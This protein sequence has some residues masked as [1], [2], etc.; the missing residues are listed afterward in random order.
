MYTK[1]MDEITFED[2]ENFCDAESEGPRVEYKQEVKDIPKIVSS[3]ANTHGGIY[4]I[5]VVAEKKNNR[6]TSIPGISEKNGIEEQI[7]QS[8]IMGIHPAVIPE[9]KVLGVPDSDNKVVVIVRVD[10]SLQAPHA[11]E[12][13]TRVYF[14]PGSITQPYQYGLADMDRI[15]YMLK[16]R[17]DSQMITRIVLSRIEE[18]V[19]HSC[20]DTSNRNITVVARPI[21]PYRPMIPTSDIYSLIWRGGKLPRRVASGACFLRSNNLEYTELNEYGI[22]YHRAVLCPANKQ[23]F[24]YRKFVFG[25]GKLIQQASELYKECQ[26]L[27]NIEVDVT[28]KNISGTKLLSDQGSLGPSSD[29]A[30]ALDSEIFASQ[31]CLYHDLH[32]QT[33]SKKIIENLTLQLLWA[34]NTPNSREMKKRIR[35][36]LERIKTSGV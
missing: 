9:I 8:A 18:R 33:E 7:Q 3:F 17:E 28:L 21:F 4:I 12:K 15:T 1:S 16:R 32:D 19:E 25:I 29:P 2:V 31:Q 24:E 5:G 30:E 11:V 34:Y 27:G 36:H 14:R 26:Y 10:E 13:T 35:T 6:V 22:V 20:F 23:E